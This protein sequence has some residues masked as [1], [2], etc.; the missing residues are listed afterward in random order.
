MFLARLLCL[1]GG[2]LL[3]ATIA[4]QGNITVLLDTT[5]L[6][7]GDPVRCT[8]VVNVPK[9]AS[10]V[11]APII[12]DVLAENNEVLELLEQG[13]PLQE[14]NE[15]YDTYQ[16]PLVF[17]AWEPG[18]QELPPLS[19]SFVHEENI[20]TLVSQAATVTAMAP[21]VTGDSTYVADIKPLLAE[22]PNFWDRL[23]QFFSHPIVAVLL[24]LLLV[25]G[26]MYLFWRYRN[27]KDVTPTPTPEEWALARWEA[28]RNSDFIPKGN[29]IGFHTEISY[30]LRGYIKGRFKIDALERPNSE[31]LPQ[32]NP[33]PLL[34]QAA[35]R[36]EL[37]TV[38]QQAD[39][40]KYAKASPLPIANEKAL[41][42][43]PE[44]IKTV[45][46]RLEILENDA[47]LSSPAKTTRR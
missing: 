9:G 12:G 14:A 45:Q 20:H 15:R 13:G 30:I 29:F 26:M 1:L 4:A 42:L 27:R 34:I 21:Q 24:F 43:I 7:I 2:C 18:M 17:T 32:L 28:L 41:A 5:Y 10:S 35:L 6:L 22:R 46:E 19:F 33:H 37:S 36:E 47:N 8:V 11:T 39:L 16:Y 31:F 25:A 23:K 40:I 3:T 38:L 44:L